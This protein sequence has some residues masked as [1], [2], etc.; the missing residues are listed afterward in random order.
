MWLK[1]CAKIDLFLYIKIWR[2]NAII[3]KIIWNVEQVE[4]V[5]RVKLEKYLPNEE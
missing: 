1:E 3:Y 2:K 4:Q 5:A